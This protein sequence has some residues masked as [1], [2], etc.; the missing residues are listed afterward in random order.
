MLSS[1]TPTNK[2]Y[3]L[4]YV[5]YLAALKRIILV[6]KEDRILVLGGQPVLVQQIMKSF[7]LKG[8]S[9]ISHLD[10]Y[11]GLDVKEDP[12]D[13]IS[14]DD[15]YSI[16]N[17]LLNVDY[18]VYLHALVEY[19]PKSIQTLFKHN[20]IYLREVLDGCLHRNIK[21]FIYCST[22]EALD[23]PL[24]L[25]PIKEE[26]TWQKNKGRSEYSK[27]RFLGELEVWRA[28]AEGLKVMVIAPTNI[29][30][31]D[32]NNHI[33]NYLLR[34]NDNNSKSCPNGS[35]GFIDVR[36]VAQFI[37]DA[38]EIEACWNEKY[39]LNAQNIS[40]IDFMEILNPNLKMHNQ[41]TSNKFSGWIAYFR[42]L[43]IPSSP[44][45]G[46]SLATAMQQSH[47]FDSTKAHSTGVFNPISLEKSMRY[48][49]NVK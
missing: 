7:V 23:R 11:V 25:E 45:P 28:M 35:G 22:T 40:Y 20:V 30:A 17:S 32:T 26:D 33:V 27:S 41:K 2:P 47:S 5:F 12:T 42:H 1:F 24:H 19:N 31:R 9:N 38:A 18:V 34:L 49:F 37:I 8:Y 15:Q 39:I 36:D 16:E 43:L 29:V 6:Q 14:L 4:I 46:S 3:P 21:G 44:F 48:W 10:I 13:S